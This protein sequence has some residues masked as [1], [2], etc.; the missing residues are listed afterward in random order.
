M[1]LELGN[2]KLLDGPLDPAFSAACRICRDKIVI[3]MDGAWCMEDS[4]AGTDLL[5]YDYFGDIGQQA[6]SVKAASALRV[7]AHCSRLAIAW[8][9]SKGSYNVL[10]L[11]NNSVLVQQ[12]SL[13]SSWDSDILSILLNIRFWA[14]Y[15]AVNFLKVDRSIVFAIV[16]CWQYI[17][18]NE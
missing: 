4:W 9:I 3:K 6:E 16:P 2:Q 5:A 1:P 13:Q 11:S 7:E 12:G 8:A 18:S 17:M 10:C 15:E 14:S